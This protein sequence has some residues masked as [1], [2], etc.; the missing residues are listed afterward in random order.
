MHKDGVDVL[1]TDEVKKAVEDFVPFNDRVILLKR[2]MTQRIMNIIRLYAPT[3]VKPE[4][5]IEEFYSDID[6]VMKV[7]KMLRLALVRM[8]SSLKLSVLR[9]GTLEVTDL[10]NSVMNIIFVP[11]IP[12]SN[13]SRDDYILGYRM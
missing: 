6:K 12:S 3:Y 2:E 7:T 5:D 13:N 11:P 8:V 4:A 10:F 1:I 9:K